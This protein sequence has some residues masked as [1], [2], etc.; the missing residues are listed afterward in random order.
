M[1]FSAEPRGGERLSLG[2]EVWS[3]EE[4]RQT[5]RIATV[6]GSGGGQAAR[7]HMRS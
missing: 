2:L 1:Y 7:H 5:E 3:S 6:A 4:P